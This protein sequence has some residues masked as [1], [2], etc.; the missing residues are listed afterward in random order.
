MS[1]AKWFDA[2]RCHCGMVRMACCGIDPCQACGTKWVM[3]N[4]GTVQASV[5]RVSW[6]G[7]LLGRDDEYRIVGE[8]R[9]EA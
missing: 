7:Y 4:S 5:R 8:F 2:Y 1:S 9:E 6:W 3:F